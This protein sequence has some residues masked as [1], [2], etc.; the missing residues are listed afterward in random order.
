M[1]ITTTSSRRP[2]CGLDTGWHL[3]KN[4]TSISLT[5]SEFTIDG[6]GA[7]FLAGDSEKPT[8]HQNCKA[9]NK[10]CLN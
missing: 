9:A 3:I 7:F 10:C 8:D 2:Q 1:C 5:G 4:G 6:V